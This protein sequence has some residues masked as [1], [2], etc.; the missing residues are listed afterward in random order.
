MLRVVAGCISSSCPGEY[1]ARRHARTS[2]LV[3]PMSDVPSS[4]SSSSSMTKTR[5]KDEKTTVREEKRRSPGSRSPLSPFCPLC[6][7]R[8][9]IS[10]RER[11][12]L[13]VRRRPGIGMPQCRLQ[14][15]LCREQTACVYSRVCRFSALAISL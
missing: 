3:A 4:S 15:Y 5:G 7:R 6:R 10:V 8:R 2:M 9:R 14:R 13:T 1:A 11:T 12:A